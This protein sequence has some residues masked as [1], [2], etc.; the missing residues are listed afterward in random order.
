[1]NKRIKK[2]L[3]FTHLRL[4]NWRNFTTVDVALW[5]R[6]FLVGP[7]ESGK[8]NLLDVFRFLHDITTAKGGF[9]S[10]VG[11]PWRGGFAKLKSLAA[12]HHADIGISVQ[13]GAERSPRLWEYELSFAQDTYS[14]PRITKE[15]IVMH[16]RVLLQ[17]P[18]KADEKDSQRL[19]QTYLE[20]SSVNQNFRGLAEFFASAS[21]VHLVPQ[22]VR[23]LLYSV[24]AD[25]PFGGGLLRRMAALPEQE[26]EGRLAI[27]RSVLRSAVPQLKE[28]EFWMNPS[29][30]KP[31]LRVRY[32]HLQGTWQLED[33]L[34]DGTL[35]L[36]GLLWA[37]LD[38]EGPVLLE[39]PELSLHPGVVRYLP[40]LFARLGQ[41]ERRQVIVTTHSPDLLRDEGIGLN[42]VLLLQPSPEGTRV[43]VARDVGQIQALVE[44]GISL[45]EAVM[46]ATSPPDG[47]GMALTGT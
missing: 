31:H 40:G 30:K 28:L 26:R 9:L 34:S 16:G 4:E 19:T 39:E 36:I 10:A 44:A 41:R 32:E 17:R 5:R 14:S 29:D 47:Q 12:R 20:Q 6:A 18:D 37:L 22:A 21:Y 3:R 13:V 27:I 23:N 2:P 45:D 38:G 15:R 7:N 1:M 42:E 11:K 24:D 46:P 8:S 25:D 33:Q 43:S 35:R